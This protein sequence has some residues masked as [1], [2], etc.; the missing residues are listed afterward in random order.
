MDARDPLTP[1]GETARHPQGFAVRRY[2]APC[3]RW[4]GAAVRPAAPPRRRRQGE[5]TTGERHDDTSGINSSACLHDR[6]AASPCAGVER[7]KRGRWRCPYAPARRPRSNDCAVLPAVNRRMASSAPASTKPLACAVSTQGYGSIIRTACS[8]TSAAS[9]AGPQATRRHSNVSGMF[10]F[11]S[12]RC[13][14]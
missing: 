4:R 10:A 5:R 2:R 14:R 12:V 13:V 3:C 6:L 7:R 11:R 8:V 1:P 9:A